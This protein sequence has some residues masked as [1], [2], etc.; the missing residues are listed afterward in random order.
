VAKNGIKILMR[1][2]KECYP[3]VTKMGWKTDT[4][5]ATLYLVDDMVRFGAPYNFSAE[6]PEHNHEYFSKNPGRRAQKNLRFEFGSAK[7]YCNKFVLDEMYA[8]LMEHSEQPDASDE[9]VPDAELPTQKLR[10]KTSIGTW[11]L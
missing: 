10:P 4:F 3:K 9:A 8:R 5:H 7:L 11:L 2:I 6:C 1:Q